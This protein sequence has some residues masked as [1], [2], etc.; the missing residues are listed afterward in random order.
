[1]SWAG[2]NRTPQASATKLGLP[3]HLPSDFFL[4]IPVP[5]RNKAVRATESSGSGLPPDR[6]L[7]SLLPHPVP[8]L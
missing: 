8:K 4:M 7:R 6:F 3:N 1:L 2:F 5:A